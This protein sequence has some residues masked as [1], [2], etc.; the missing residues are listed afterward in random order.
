M[1]LA[2]EVAKYRKLVTA[3]VGAAAELVSLGFLPNQA[4][5]WVAAVVAVLTTLGV[6]AVPNAPAPVP[7]VVP[8]VV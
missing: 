4:Q 2:T 5:S 1:S 8:P 3:G 6:Y 7:V